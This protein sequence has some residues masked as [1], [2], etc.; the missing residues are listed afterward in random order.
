[1]IGNKYGRWTVIGYSEDKRK[2]RCRCE[3]GN[4]SDVWKSNLR[5][6]KTLS[7]G[8]L[9]SEATT[10]RNT[11]HNGTKTRLYSVWNN[12]LRRCYEE[13]NNR[14]HRYGGRGINVCDEW[15]EF[16]AF[17][18]WMLS[19][20]YDEKSE[21]GKQTLDRI[22]NDGNYEPSNCRLTSIKEQNSNRSTRHLLTYNGETHSITEW[23][24]IMGYS[25][26]VIDNRI[27]KG[28]SADRAISTPQK[29][30]RA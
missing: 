25:D 12:M 20:G 11:T 2:M 26:G 10:K 29:R 7:C 9:I 27:R 22:D 13:K 6:G 19:Q 14:Y 4:E 3:C 17:R 24:T 15:H 5:S 28:W 21:Y 16:S 23:N 18:E 30:K 8:C 1:M